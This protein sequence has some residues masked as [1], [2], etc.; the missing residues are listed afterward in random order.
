MRGLAA[1][2]QL[3]IWKPVQSAG[4][5]LFLCRRWQPLHCHLP[6]LLPGQGGAEARWGWGASTLHPSAVCEGRE[7]SQPGPAGGP[8]GVCRRTRRRSLWVARE[9]L[10]SD[11]RSRGSP[12]RSS[13]RLHPAPGHTMPAPRASCG[14]V[15]APGGPGN[16]E[17]MTLRVLPDRQRHSVLAPSGPVASRSPAPSECPSP[18]LGVGEPSPASVWCWTSMSAPASTAPN[19]LPRS[20]WRGPLQL[21]AWGPWPG[22]SNSKGSLQP[23]Q[24]QAAWPLPRPKA[25]VPVPLQVLWLGGPRGCGGPEEAVG[26]GRVCLLRGPGASPPPHSPFLLYL[27]PSPCRVAVSS[28]RGRWVSPSTLL[29]ASLR[30]GSQDQG[31]HVHAVGV[32]QE[33]RGA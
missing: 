9:Q 3:L 30:V 7:G 15:G 27:H 23:W 17:Q 25:H 12:F 2:M 18:G 26:L 8:G 33:S 14:H 1:G 6:M 22:G 29:G 10:G 4:I 31:L 24:P 5:Y 13:P 28:E 11:H 21:G 16:D 20:G 32:V 19:S